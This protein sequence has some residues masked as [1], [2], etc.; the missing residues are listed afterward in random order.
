MHVL[1]FNIRKQIKIC[2]LSVID[3]FFVTWPSAKTSLEYGWLQCGASYLYI[4]N[5][6]NQLWVCLYE[7]GFVLGVE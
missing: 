5:V 6:R 7:I 3:M 4:R 2:T 1:V